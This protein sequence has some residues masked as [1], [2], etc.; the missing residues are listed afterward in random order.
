MSYCIMRNDDMQVSRMCQC[1]V[2]NHLLAARPRLVLHMTQPTSHMSR[3]DHMLYY[4]YMYI[5]DR[6]SRS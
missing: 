5:R 1:L 3:R 6:N 2:H 4:D